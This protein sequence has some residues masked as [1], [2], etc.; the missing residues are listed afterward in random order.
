[1]D[2]H[3]QKEFQVQVEMQFNVAPEYLF[4]SIQDGHIFRLTGT[5]SLRMDFREQGAYL[6]DFEKDRVIEGTFNTIIPNTTVNLIWNVRG[7]RLVPDV[8]TLV[9]F[10]I[11]GFEG[12]SRLQILHSRIKTHASAEGKQQGWTT[13][14]SNLKTDLEK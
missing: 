6:M 4:R 13:V 10:S 14:L 1:M 7:F 12:G 8:E 9:T 5:K 11:S 3:E 2:V